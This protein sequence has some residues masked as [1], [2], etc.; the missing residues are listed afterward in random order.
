M[1]KFSVVIPTLNRAYTLRRTLPH[2]FGLRGVDEIILVSDAGT[3]ETESLFASI[4]ADH[5]SV[6]ARFVRNEVRLGAAGIRAQAAQLAR[7]ELIL[8]CDD[9]VVLDANYAM[10]C[11]RLLE[12]PKPA[13]RCR[14]PTPARVVN[15]I[16]RGLL[17]TCCAS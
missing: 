4:A 12:D 5:P 14:A 1:K 13:R 9:D 17:I 15:G 8:F 2:C 7:N 10:C 16:A 11:A 3:D 6:H